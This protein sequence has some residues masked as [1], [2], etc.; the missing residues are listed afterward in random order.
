MSSRRQ[1]TGGS[2]GTSR[3]GLRFQ[4]PFSKKKNVSLSLSIFR[5]RACLSFGIDN[6]FF[7]RALVG[8]ELKGGGRTRLLLGLKLIFGKRVFLP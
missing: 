2:G 3:S 8:E 7:C 1:G 5:S 6:G 4:M